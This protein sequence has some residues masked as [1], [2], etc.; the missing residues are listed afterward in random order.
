MVV[1]RLV[2][3]SHAGTAA[4]GASTAGELRLLPGSN[5]PVAVLVPKEINP[6]ISNLI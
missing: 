6:L 4:L 2:L 5:L 3:S 1:G